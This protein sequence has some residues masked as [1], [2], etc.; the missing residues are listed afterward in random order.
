MCRKGPAEAGGLG[1]RSEQRP[2]GHTPPWRCPYRTDPKKHG[3][4]RVISV[5]EAL[6]SLTV[7]TGRSA[8]GR[9]PRQMVSEFQNSQDKPGMG[10]GTTEQV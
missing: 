10:S 7:L 9:G 1:A 3:R 6:P 5:P 2:L 8:G 4:S